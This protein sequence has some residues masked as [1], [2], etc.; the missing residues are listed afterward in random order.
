MNHA[1]AEVVRNTNNV[2]G[3]N[4]IYKGCEGLEI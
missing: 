4:S 2:A 3:N 1:L